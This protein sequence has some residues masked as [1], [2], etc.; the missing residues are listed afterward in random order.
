MA[1]EIERK[2]LV[3]EQRWQAC[4]QQHQLRGQL[5]R[6]GYLA[7]NQRVTVRARVKG[8]SGWLTLKG[9]TQGISRLEYEVP[10]PQQDADEIL[11]KLCQPPLIEKTRFCYPLGAHTWE[12]DE[13]YGENQGLIV[14]EIELSDADDVFQKPDWLGEEVSGEARYYNLNLAKH[15]YRQW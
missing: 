10:I 3:D 9:A 11:D 1:I 5:I 7:D 2:F 4:K 12:V 13:F 15:P 6:Q 14:A 8:G